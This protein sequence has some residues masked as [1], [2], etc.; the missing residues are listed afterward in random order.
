[1]LV[2]ALRNLVRT[3][4]FEPLA[5]LASREGAVAIVGDQHSG[6]RWGA[7]TVI[8]E[9][10]LPAWEFVPD[11]DKPD[12]SRLAC[13]PNSS[14]LLDL[15]GGE[16]L[17]SDFGMGL[18]AYSK[19][20]LELGSRLFMLLT[21][22]QWRECRSDAGHIEN[23]FVHKEFCEIGLNGVCIGSLRRTEVHEQN[24]IV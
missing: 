1:M 12:L 3:D 21:A 2:Q 5:N 7:Y 9:R 13:E 8:A 22:D 23:P 17:G 16:P 6:R 19:K 10:R 18:A 14:Y 20:L 24:G 4:S 11:W 15:T